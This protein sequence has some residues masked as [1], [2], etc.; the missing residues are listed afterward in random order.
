MAISANAGSDLSQRNPKKR[1]PSFSEIFIKS[2]SYNG[3]KNN[4]LSEQISVTP[5]FARIWALPACHD[6]AAIQYFSIIMILMENSR[7]W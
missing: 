5:N 7:F 4:C 3:T 6:F 2:K 1:W